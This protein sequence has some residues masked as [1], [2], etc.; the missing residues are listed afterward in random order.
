MPG[1]ERILPES[2]NYR[3][4]ELLE[5]LV[6]ANGFSPSP[7]PSVEYMRGVTS[8][9]RHPIVYSPRIVIV[10]QG[11]KC[12]W[13]GDDAYVY[14][15]N[16]YLVLSA[17]M[18]MECETSASEEEPLLGLAISIDPILVGELLLEMGDIPGV[19]PTTCVRSSAMTEDVID[20]SI[21]LVETLASPVDARI[22]G[23]QIVRE[24]VYR[25][26]RSENGDVL[27]LATTNASRFGH[28]ARVLRRIHEEYATDLDVNSLAREA[29]MGASTFHHAFREVT[30]TSP[31]QY[32]KRIRLHR[33]RT[34]LAGEGASAQEAARRVGYASA[35]QFSR[36]YRRMF[37]VS[38]AADRT[39]ISA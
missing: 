26:L 23:P 32:V 16:N 18:P 31:V 29:N 22:L 8:V 17:P 15:A 6:T 11:R 35:S 1:E 33:A 2:T 25:V 14:D 38:P 5:P 30:A 36:E 10:A 19:D 24:I 7:V 27:R 21:R 4:A 3:L 20:A 39:S 34:L 13:L 37:G 12:V 28:I 9:P